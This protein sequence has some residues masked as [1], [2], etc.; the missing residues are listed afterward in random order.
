MVS[1]SILPW[2]RGT[3]KELGRS[4]LAGRDDALVVR[5]LS[6]LVHLSARRAPGVV[7]RRLADLGLPGSK[8]KGRAEGDDQKGEKG[9]RGVSR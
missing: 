4:T 9:R 8:G 5:E 1:S 2:P 3:S 7:G 6:D